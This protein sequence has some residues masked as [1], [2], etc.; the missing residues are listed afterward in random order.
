MRLPHK[1]VPIKTGNFGII[2]DDKQEECREE[3]EV[4]GRVDCLF[5]T[6]MLSLLFENSTEMMTM[7]YT[8][9]FCPIES[10]RKM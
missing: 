4:Y 9:L 7:S 1:S 10:Q 3:V 5:D 8:V 6:T 2:S